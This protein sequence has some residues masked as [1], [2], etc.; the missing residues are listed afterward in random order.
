MDV[1]EIYSVI[2]KNVSRTKRTPLTEF[3][4]FLSEQIRVK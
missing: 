2:H 4:Q 1:Y 3:F